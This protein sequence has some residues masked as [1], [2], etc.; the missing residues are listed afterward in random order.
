MRTL[1]LRIAGLSRHTKTGIS[2]AAFLKRGDHR[3]HIATGKS[4]NADAGMLER[5]FQGKADGAADQNMNTDVRQLLD[6][7]KRPHTRQIDAFPG[8]FVLFRHVDQ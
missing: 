3:I 2:K 7:A 1:A 6:P 8:D 5:T 4:D